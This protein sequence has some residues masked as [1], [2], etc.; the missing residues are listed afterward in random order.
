MHDVSERRLDERYRKHFGYV[1]GY[2]PRDRRA[3][4]AWHGKLK[5]Q[6]G[7]QA[8]G[9]D[10]MPYPPAVEALQ[11]LILTNGIVRMYL[12][13][14]IAQ[15]PDGHR[16]VEN[17]D[18]LLAAL[19]AIV[20]T[21]PSYNPD[22]SKMNAFPMSTLFTYMMMTTAGEILFR[23]TEFNDVL[24]RI[25]KEWCVFLDSPASRSVLTEDEDGWLGRSAF[26]YNRLWEFSFNR[27]EPYW[28]YKSYNDFFHRQ[29][30]LKHR[31]VAAPAN[32]KVIVSANDGTVFNIET[33]AQRT[34]DFWLKGQRYS[35][36]D[37]LAGRHV[38]RFVG[39]SVFQ[40]FLSGANYHRWRAPIDGTVVDAR[41]V[42]GLMFSDAESAGFDDTAATYSQFY[43]TAVNTR[44]LV[45]I[46][47]DDANIGMVCVVPI[48][49]TEISSVKINVS[50]GT[51]VRKGDELGWFSYGGS[52]M[53][54]VFEPGAIDLFTVPNR[55][56]GDDPD[57]GPPIRVNQQIALAR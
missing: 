47:S 8:A 21:A 49:I 9:G 7:Q 52:A 14:M 26:F 54:L 39:G 5:R 53:A 44:G 43:E 34:T 24:R 15:Q 56:A 18:E 3:V 12:M 28:G 35:L 36:V 11:Q 4:D 1:A 19:T 30:D 50:V 29:I 10:V 6:L 22:P 31:P 37:M 40:S 57:S 16:V 45:F 33:N 17:V 48:G 46:Q 55:S 27:K 23:N 42:D 38:D 32:P 25:L 2:L 41:V 20:T 13:Q 51:K